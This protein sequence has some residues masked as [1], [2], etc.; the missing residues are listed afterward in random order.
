[1]GTARRPMIAEATSV[2]MVFSVVQ[3]IAMRMMACRAM[4][5]ELSRNAF[6]QVFGTQSRIV[7]KARKPFDGGFLIF[8]GRGDPG[9]RTRP[10][11]EQGL[12]KSDKSFDL[13]TMSPRIKLHDKVGQ[14]SGTRVRV[15]HKPRLSPVDNSLPLVYLQN[16]SRLKVSITKEM[17]RINRRYI[18]TASEIGEFAYCQ[19]AWYLKRC[20]EVSHSPHLE[21]GTAFHA[22][23]E[24]GVSQAGRLNRAGKKLG[25]VAL[26]LLVV[27]A[28]IWVVTEM[29]R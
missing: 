4:R 17:P 9:L 2:W 7:Q 11:F 29:S 12:D 5:D 14:A 3:S 25:V 18:I 21:T 8:K 28:F 20:G 1:M 16:V 27:I 22:T 24:A 23:H 19:K 13:M 26:V 15:R 6:G 10:G